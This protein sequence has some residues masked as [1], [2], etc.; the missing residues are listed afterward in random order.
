M[1]LYVEDGTIASRWVGWAT[2]GRIGVCG[3]DDEYSADCS[4]EVE[5][6]TFGH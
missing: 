2:D 4:V 6:K 5:E 1:C 3:G